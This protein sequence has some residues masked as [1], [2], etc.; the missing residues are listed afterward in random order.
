M[1]KFPPGTSNQTPAFP[2]LEG[3]VGQQTFPAEI[4]LATCGNFNKIV[5]ALF[6]HSKSLQKTSSVLSSNHFQLPQR[7]SG[8]HRERA[9]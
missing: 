4:Q 7:I 5:K 2:P 6:N 1:A 3:Q 9:S 8:G